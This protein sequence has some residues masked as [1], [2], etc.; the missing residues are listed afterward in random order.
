MFYC[1]ASHHATVG[2]SPVPNDGHRVSH[3]RGA[4]TIGTRRPSGPSPTPGNATTP[5][6]ATSPS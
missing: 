5:S 1:Y 4:V 2:R 6:S 3:D